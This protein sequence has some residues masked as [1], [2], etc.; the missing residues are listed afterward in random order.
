MLLD[1]NNRPSAMGIA[2]GVP[3]V[4]K[5]VAQQMLLVLLKSGEAS[6]QCITVRVLPRSTPGVLA[7]ALLAVLNVSHR[8]R[9]SSGSADAL[10]QAIRQQNL[11]L[12]LLDNADYLNDACLDM[13][14]HLTDTTACAVFM[15][16][17]HRFLERTLSRERL[18]YR[19][20]IRLNFQPPAFEE[21]LHVVLP[22]LNFAGWIFNPANEADCHLAREIWSHTCPSLRRLCNLLSL[23]SHLT[24]LRGEQTITRRAIRNTLDLI[25]SDELL[26][27]H[28]SAKNKGERR[29]SRRSEDI[30]I[31]AKERGRI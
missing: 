12:L 2:T 26:Q 20:V 7:E 17:L 16:G 18:E 27:T 28:T 6:I 9:G 15:V 1:T 23:A 22:Q 24:Q 13:L 31:E 21:V 3:G 4:G 29:V 5:T 14:C 11:Q 30:S 8:V 19:V 10:A 25:G